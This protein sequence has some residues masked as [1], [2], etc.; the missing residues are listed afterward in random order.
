MRKSLFSAFMFGSALAAS[1]VLSL[2][3]TAAPASHQLSPK[4]EQGEPIDAYING[5]WDQLSRSMDECK[6]IVDPKLATASILYLPAN[7]PEPPEIIALEKSCN[8]KVERLPRRIQHIGDIKPS[9]I[10]H[11]GL[12][13]LPNK[14]VVPGG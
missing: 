9:E 1:S 3:Q 6:S 8:I 11:A 4:A 2:G 14:Y 7:V 10:A 5:A 13:Y 12:L